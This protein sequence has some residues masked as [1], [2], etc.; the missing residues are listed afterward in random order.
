MCG[1]FCFVSTPNCGLIPFP[2]AGCFKFK[3]R[4]VC[5]AAALPG[6]G[7]CLGEGGGAAAKAT[8]ARPRHPR[9]LFSLLSRLEN[10]PRLRGG[11]QPGARNNQPGV[12]P[13][14]THPRER[15][16]LAFPPPPSHPTRANRLMAGAAVLAE[17]GY[18]SGLLK[19]LIA[20]TGKIDIGKKRKSEDVWR[21][22]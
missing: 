13:A 9:A 12:P 10:T 17:R 21:H 14:H 11:E 1:L 20:N 19:M 22:Q 6:R 15:H 18:R 2:R 8:P 7:V 5:D 3:Y 4:D 16:G